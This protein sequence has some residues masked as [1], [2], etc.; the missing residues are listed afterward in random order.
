MPSYISHAIMGNELYKNLEEEKLLYIPIDKK[1]LRSYTS[2]P[3]YALMSK[4]VIKNTHSTYTRL[5]FLNMIS[6]I[7]ENKL[8]E[9]S[10]VLSLLYAHIS[11]Y[12]LDINT[13]PLINYLEDNCQTNNILS[14]HTIIEGYIDSYLSQ[15][16][17][18]KDIKEIKPS[19]FTK[20]DFYDKDLIELINNIYGKVYNDYNMIDTYKSVQRLIKSL[21]ILI[22]SKF[23]SKQTLISFSNF[24]N[25]LINNNLTLDNLTNENKDIYIDLITGEYLTNSFLELYQKS[26]IMTL[27]AIYEVNRYLIEDK[28]ISNLYKVFTDLSYNTGVSCKLENSKIYKRT[29]EKRKLS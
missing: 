13:H 15:K 23:I 24:H 7:K 14:N 21:E 26:I 17:L 27:E 16:I 1:E 2:T 10:N 22:K 20:V 9:N 25:F 29:K 12:F 8:L 19:Y 6:Y 18:N 28:P 4:R 11:H 3:D 5:F